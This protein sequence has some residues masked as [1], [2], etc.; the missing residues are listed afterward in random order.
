M[1]ISSPPIIS[2]CYYGIDTPTKEEL[3]GALKPVREICDYITADSLQYLSE[4]GMLR[5]VVDE[6]NSTFCTACFTDRYP[7]PLLPEES[8]QLG[9]FE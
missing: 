9:L 3:I 6:Q 7:I 2:P 5:A 8:P 4:E 1:R